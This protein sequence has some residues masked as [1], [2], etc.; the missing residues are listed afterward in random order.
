VPVEDDAF[1]LPDRTVTLSLS[2]SDAL[3]TIGTQAT[4][5]L[6]IT[7]DDETR[8]TPG[9]DTIEPRTVVNAP[10]SV[11]LDALLRRGVKVTARPNEAARL[12]FALDRSGSVVASKSLGLAAGKRSVTLKPGARQLA[13][14]RSFT[15]RLRVVATDAAGNSATVTRTITVNR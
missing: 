6:T 7:D 11:S 3:V 13:A 2:S 8:V 4:A 1:D 5:T 15:L 10:R 12:K 9:S 14:R